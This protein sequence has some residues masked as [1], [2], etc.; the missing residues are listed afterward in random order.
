MPGLLGLSSKEGTASVEMPGTGAAHI[1]VLSHSSAYVHTD[2]G[3][4][5]QAHRVFI[6]QTCLCAHTH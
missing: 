5:R 4:H 3:V 2:T 1:P 6:T